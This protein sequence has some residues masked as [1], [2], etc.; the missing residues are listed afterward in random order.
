[1]Y[2]CTYVRRMNLLKQAATFIEYAVFVLQWP[3]ACF[4]DI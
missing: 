1:M 4:S 3:L 2:A